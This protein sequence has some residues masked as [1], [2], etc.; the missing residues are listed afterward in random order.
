[1]VYFIAKVEIED[2]NGLLIETVTCDIKFRKPSRARKECDKITKYYLHLD[3]T[4]PIGS[5]AYKLVLA[6]DFK[7]RMGKK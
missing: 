6:R 1:M 2:P 5:K 7:K 4:I 3:N